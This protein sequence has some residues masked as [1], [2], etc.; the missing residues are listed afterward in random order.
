M[1][2]ILEDDDLDYI[3]LKHKVLGD[4]P[5]ERHSELKSLTQS[6]TNFTLCIVDL[7]VPD[8]LG[9][10]IVKEV[11]KKCKRVYVLTGMADGHISGKAVKNI[12]DAGAE[13]LFFKASLLSNNYVS[14]MKNKMFFKD[15]R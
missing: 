10:E 12:T 13:G 5:H 15:G 9:V 1:I 8:A 4:T 14:E 3:F 6:N 7:N 11:K 2:G